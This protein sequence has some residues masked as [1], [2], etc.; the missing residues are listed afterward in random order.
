M[1]RILFFAAM[2][3]I[4]DYCHPLCLVVPWII[5]HRPPIMLFQFNDLLLQTVFCIMLNC[6]KNHIGGGDGPNPT[7]PQEEMPQ[8][9]DK[10][11]GQKVSFMFAQNAESLWLVGRND[12]QLQL[13][14][15]SSLYS[16]FPP[17]PPPLPPPSPPTPCVVNTSQLQVWPAIS[18]RQR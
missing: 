14:L 8:R 9:P 2:Y 4:G 7:P 16:P 6:N 17:P 1:P 15:V 11:F 5:C 3:C 12:R 10:P 18:G 13:Q